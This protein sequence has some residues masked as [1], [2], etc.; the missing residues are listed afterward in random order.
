MRIDDT[1]IDHRRRVE[2]CEIARGA[3]EHPPDDARD[4]DAQVKELEGHD[5]EALEDHVGEEEV[6]RATFL[7]G[8]GELLGD[9]GG[10]VGEVADELP[11]GRGEEEDEDDVDQQE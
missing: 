4:D 6:A 10:G 5:A 8:L 9:L 2:L 1:I 11:V 7:E 3:S